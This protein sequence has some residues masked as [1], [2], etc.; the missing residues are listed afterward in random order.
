MISNGGRFTLAFAEIGRKQKIIDLRGISKKLLFKA[1]KTAG[2]GNA[3]L[4]QF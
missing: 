1:F 3:I 2:S 4:D